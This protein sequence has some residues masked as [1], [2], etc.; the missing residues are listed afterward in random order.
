MNYWIKKVKD[1]ANAN[2][3]LQELFKLVVFK[4]LRAQKHNRG[5]NTT[6]AIASNNKTMERELDP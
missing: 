6:N 4:L 5:I 1:F 2:K 3:K